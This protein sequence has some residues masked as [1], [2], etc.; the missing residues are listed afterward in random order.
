MTSEFKVPDQIPLTG[1]TFIDIPDGSWMAYRV[2]FDNDDAKAAAYFR[3]EMRNRV[4]HVDQSSVRFSIDV[5]GKLETAGPFKNMPK[6]AAAW[7]D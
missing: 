2:T 3:G 7:D 5:H 6:G 1:E 4:I